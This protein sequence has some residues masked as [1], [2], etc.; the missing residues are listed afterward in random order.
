[1]A[2]RVRLNQPLTA[3]ARQ[4]RM[5]KGKGK[6]KGWVGYVRP[7]TLIYDLGPTGHRSWRQH[8]SAATRLGG[9][10]PLQRL[11]QRLPFG[12]RPR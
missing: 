11:N 5:G 9:A 3:K 12:L 6:F 1:V 4:S 10:F 7:G 2:V 8:P